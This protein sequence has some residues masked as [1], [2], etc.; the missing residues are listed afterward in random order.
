FLVRARPGE[1][2]AAVAAG[3]P[4][5]VEGLVLA[6]GELP[7]AGLRVGGG[8][9]ALAGG[10]GDEGG[11]DDGDVVRAAGAEEVG[12]RDGGAAAGGG[13]GDDA[14]L[15]WLGDVGGEAHELPVVGEGEAFG[16]AE[17][18]VGDANG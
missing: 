4:H 17:A 13:V 9:A 14:Q 7:W 10:P 3:D 11:A 18:V 8:G 12:A 6:A 16:A 15:E 1:G 2:E 5:A